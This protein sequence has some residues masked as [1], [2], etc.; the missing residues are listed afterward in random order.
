MGDVVTIIENGTIYKI[1]QISDHLGDFHR[2]ILHGPN[3]I[4]DKGS[5]DKE[6]MMQ[7]LREMIEQTGGRII[8]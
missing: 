7:A 5:D 8:E 3:K 6:K 1:A 4:L 2:Y